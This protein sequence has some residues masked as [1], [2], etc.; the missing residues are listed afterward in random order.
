MS[1]GPRCE[2]ICYQIRHTAAQLQKQVKNVEISQ[3]AS[4]AVLI[5]T[6]KESDPTIWMR[7]SKKVG[8]GAR[9]PSPEESQSYRV[10]WQYCSWS[11]EKHNATKLGHHQ[12]ARCDFFPSKIQK[13]VAKF[14]VCWSRDWRFILHRNCIDTWWHDQHFI[15]YF[16]I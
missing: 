16:S 14:V 7:R 8:G 6:E 2:K 4:L 10:S 12:P 11:P 5:S 1:I 15:H 13:D 9:T 3:V